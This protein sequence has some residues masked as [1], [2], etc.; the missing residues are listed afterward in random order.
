MKTSIKMLIL[1]S[2][3]VGASSLANEGRDGRENSAERGT[4]GGG[5]FVQGADG[6]Y[7]LRDLVDESIC[8][9]TTGVDMRKENPAIDAALNKIAAL[10][11]YFAASLKYEINK[12]AICMTKKLVQLNT[13]DWDSVIDYEPTNKEV[14]AIRLM[15]TNKVYT[16]RDLHAKI[17]KTDEER[18][19]H[20]AFLI[21][22]EAMHSFI[23]YDAS[24]R[25]DSLR[26]AVATL[27]KV[28]RGEISI[29]KKFHQEMTTNQVAFPFDSPILKGNRL[30]IEFALA[31]PE[32]QKATLL[33][34]ENIDS[35]NVEETTGV[36]E[37]HR[38]EI[39]E[40][41][42]A[43][44]SKLLEYSGTD[45]SVLKKI[46]NSQQEILTFDALM[47][48]LSTNL[49]AEN[50]QYRE[51]VMKSKAM[52]AGPTLF[53]KMK[54]KDFTVSN[55]RV[56]GNAGYELL[57]IAERNGVPTPALSVRP[58]TVQEKDLIP[59]E[60]KGF[61]QLLV[62]YA[63]H[64]EF[65]WDLIH[66]LVTQSDKFYAAFSVRELQTKLESMQTPVPREKV[67]LLEALPQLSIGLR[68]VL[69]HEMETNVGPE[70]AFKL[71]QEIKWSQLVLPKNQ[72]QRN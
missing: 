44:A 17:G 24:Q 27:E 1:A 7:Y 72:N 34:V 25:N 71:D 61:I 35:L 66:A 5:E 48:A 43:R 59:A 22:H 56:V 16:D 50:S 41:L 52:N 40:T 15:G 63:E 20:Q 8:D 37:G 4:R 26:N 42:A 45:L 51:M 65:G 9:R 21:V 33:K 11:W 69:F 58:Y 55:L 68:K 64:G 2:L 23:P 57:G 67:A 13:K 18:Q 30:A 31:S 28:S 32:D 6:N 3:L 38:S 70:A 14:G 62:I 54:S 12:L 60:V 53:L 10:N 47:V 39:S 46:V 29:R 36:Y 19:T 49:A